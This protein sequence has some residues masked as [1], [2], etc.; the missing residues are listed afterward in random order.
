[1]SNVPKNSW[2]LLT[3]PKDYLPPTLVRAGN[4][5]VS[6]KTNIPRR[7]Y[8]DGSVWDIFGEYNYENNEISVSETGPHPP[9][10]LLHELGH[11][12]YDDL[13]YDQKLNWDLAFWTDMVNYK[14]KLLSK[15]RTSSDV[16]SDQLWNLYTSYDYT[17]RHG[18]ARALS[19][20]LSK[21]Q[22][23]YENFPSMVRSLDN[24]IGG[25]WT[26]DLTGVKGPPYRPPAFGD[27]IKPPD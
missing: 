13:S 18:Y 20:Y 12:D 1:M 16:L 26:I 17:P 10:T 5:N 24:R 8:E 7:H 15:S 25:R 22:S 4:A 27:K 11:S 3:P 23:F 6:T 21:D 9:L 19:Q 14:N 2:V